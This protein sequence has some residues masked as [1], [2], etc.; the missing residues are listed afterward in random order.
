MEDLVQK[1]TAKY[2]ELSDYHDALE[3]KCQILQARIESLEEMKMEVVAEMQSAID[4]RKQV[5]SLL[6]QLHGLRRGV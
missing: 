5:V 2:Q 1:L 4:G 3:R 6:E